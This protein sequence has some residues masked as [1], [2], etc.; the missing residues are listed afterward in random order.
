M[1]T[2]LY[3]LSQNY[4]QAL[5]FL[6]DPENDIDTTTIMDTLE[7]LDGEIDDKI[8]SVAKMI[9]MLD[10][11]AE[12]IKA[13]AKKQAERAK[14]LEQKAAWLREYLK[15]NM[16]RIDHVKVENSEISVKLATTPPT[17]KIIDEA[18]I[19]EEFW[20]TKTEIL[21]DKVMIKQMGGC[22]G[23]IIESGM[24]VRIK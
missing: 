18:L 19:P 8:I 4:Y 23:A 10:H 5:D 1:K 21:P 17:V 13:V 11:D 9:V 15:D 12:G 3:Q 2:T 20:R 24:A 22:P 16:L 7:G 6:T 14:A